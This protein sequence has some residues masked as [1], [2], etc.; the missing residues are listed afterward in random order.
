MKYGFHGCH[1]SLYYCNVQSS[2]VWIQGTVVCNHNVV[3]PFRNSSYLLIWSVW[4]CVVLVTW[5][6][7]LLD[8]LG[9]LGSLTPHLSHLDWSM[10][11]ISP[12]VLFSCIF[13]SK[14]YLGSSWAFLFSDSLGWLFYF[15]CR[16][17]LPPLTVP[18]GMCRGPSICICICWGRQII[19]ICIWI[20]AEKA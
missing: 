18:L 8:I 9:M 7:C 20:K 5:Q 2:D 17:C 16:W 13:W 14:V 6:D 19:Y 10:A 3:F 12:H 4:H 11:S 15:P 1:H